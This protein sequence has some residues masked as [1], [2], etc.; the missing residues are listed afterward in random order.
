MNV[1]VFSGAGVSQESGINTFRDI[2]DGLWY[3]HKVDEV[4]SLEGWRKD[5]ELVL[6]FHNILRKGIADKVP[7]DAHLCIH[8]WE[9]EHD[10]TVI[11]QNI[12]DLHEQAG[13]SKVLHL[14]GELNKCRST[15]DD[16]IFELEGHTLNI[17]E[18]C[19]R[20]SQLRPHSVLFGEYPYNIDESVAALQVADVLV[21][22]GTSLQISYTVPMLQ[23]SIQPSCRVYYVDPEPDESVGDWF[24]QVEFIRENATSGITKVN[25]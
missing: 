9:W 1:V 2:K 18:K 22:V 12:D 6:D 15:L 21:I 16:T 7:N 13:S 8:E 23:Y 17:G 11:T 25:F 20:G 5:R 4:A 10:V 24:N 3:N 14:H 19:P